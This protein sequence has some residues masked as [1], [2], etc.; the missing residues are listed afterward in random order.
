M[1]KFRSHRG[2]KANQKSP[3]RPSR[4]RKPF[5]GY[6]ITG[7]SL[8]TILTM[9]Y[10]DSVGNATAADVEEIVEEINTDIYNAARTGEEF[11]KTSY[12][13]SEV[14]SI[15]AKEDTVEVTFDDGNK[16]VVDKVE[17]E[18]FEN[19]LVTVD[20]VDLSK[21]TKAQLLEHSEKVGIKIYKSWTKTKM[22]DTLSA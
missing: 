16:F 20:L 4:N 21:M 22:I 3:S 11:D 7:V 6:G 10:F 8:I 14:K 18:P 19:T 5:I 9:T 12:E 13:V 1:R 17:D 15:V 2:S